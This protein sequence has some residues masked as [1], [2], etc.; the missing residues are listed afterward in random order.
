VN[1]ANYCYYYPEACGGD[2]GGGDISMIEDGGDG[3]FDYCYY[4]PEYC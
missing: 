2:G 3:G 4:Y 1:D